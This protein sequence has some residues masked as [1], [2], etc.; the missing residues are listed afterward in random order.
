MTLAISHSPL[1]PTSAVGEGGGGLIKSSPCKWIAKEK[2]LSG[3]HASTQTRDLSPDAANDIAILARGLQVP[4]TLGPKA[5][6]QGARGSRFILI[7]D[8]G[9]SYLRQE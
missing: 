8:E 6:E 1:S 4:E 2:H 5:F 7:R 9:K 3:Q